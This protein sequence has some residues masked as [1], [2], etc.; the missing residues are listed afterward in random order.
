MS[1]EEWYQKEINELILMILK[2]KSQQELTMLFDR[3]LTPREIN[4]MA[5]RLKALEL[6][7]KG[8]SYSEIRERLGLSPVIISRLA[9]KIGYG[10][11][12]SNKISAKRD[13]LSSRK[14]SIP[15]KTIRYK[16]IPVFRVPK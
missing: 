11:R 7:E 15:K 1:R 8:L 5:R 3:I 2:I 12:R 4:D 16:G 10:F 9:N 14:S 13:E 6:L